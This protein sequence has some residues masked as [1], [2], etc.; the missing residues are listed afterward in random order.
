M[1]STLST[2][3]GSSGGEDDESSDDSNDDDFA[4]GT[5]GGS[6][7]KRTLRMCRCSVAL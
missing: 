3:F 4:D 7:R 2:L 6:D 5:Y 1:A